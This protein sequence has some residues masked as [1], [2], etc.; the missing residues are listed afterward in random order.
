MCLFA[1]ALAPPPLAAQDAQWIWTPEHQHER[2]P[3]E[4]CFFR[5]TFS[6]AAAPEN[7]QIAIAADDRFELYVNS[8]QVGT[9]ESTQRLIPFNVTRYLVRGRNTVAVKVENVRGGTAALAARVMVKQSEGGWSSYSTDASWKTHLRPLPLWNLPIY[10]DSRWTE[11]QVFGLLGGTPP[12]DRIPDATA[13]TGAAGDTA[14]S[15]D[16][17][18]HD[19]FQIASE[20]EV[21]KVLAGEALGS[22]IALTFNEFGHVIASQEGGPLLLITDSNNDGALDKMRVYCE[23][24]KNCQGILSLNGDVY[25]TGEGPDGAALYRLSDGD[26]DGVLEHAQPLLKF[27]GPMGEHGPHALVLGPDGKIYLI[28]GNHAKPLAALDERSPH[29]KFYEGDLVGPRFEDPGGHA[30]GIKAPG[31]VV[32]RMDVDGTHVQVVA[33]GLRNCYDLAFNYEGELFVH[34]SDMESDVGAPWYRPTNLYHIIPGGEYGWRSGWAKWPEYFVDVLP[35]VLDT[36]RGSPTG[37]VFYNHIMFPTRYHDALFLAD[38]SEGRILVVR[39]KRSGATYT[40]SSEV[41]LKGEPLNVTDL[42]VGPDGSL[43]FTTGGR[44]TGGGLHRVRWRGTVP[45]NIRN[46]GADLTAVVRQPQLSAAWSRQNIAGLK[47]KLGDTWDRS[48]VGIAR[49]EQNPPNYRLRALDLLELYGPQPTTDLLI[50][51]AGDKNEQV[52]GKAAAMMGVHFDD[53]TRDKLVELLS[54]G[55]R[56]VRRKAAESLVR[57]GQTVPAEKVL[58][59]LSS[60]DRHEAWAARR[61]LERIDPAEWRATVLATGDQRLFIEGSLALLIAHPSRETALSVVERCGKLMEGFISDRNFVDMLR[62]MQVALHRGQL[63]AADVPA[64]RTKLENEFP[65]GDAIMNRE[66]ARLLVYLQVNTIHDRYLAYLKS[67]AAEAEKLHLAMHLRFLPDGMTQDQKR[68][69]LAFYETVQDDSQGNS[70]PHY[71]RNAARDFALSLGPEDADLLLAGGERWPSAA[72]GVLYKLPQ[73]LDAATF[74][75]LKQLDAKIAA[76]PSEAADRLKVGIVAVMARSGD[77]DSMDYL[78]GLWQREPERRQAVAMGLAQSP[79]GDNW[80]LLVDSLSVVEGGAA[81]EVL[82]KLVEVNRVP[83]NPEAYRHVILLGLV[84][85]AEGGDLAVN[86]LRFWS[87]EKPEGNETDWQKSLAAWQTWY[88][89]KYPDRPPAELPQVKDDAPWDYQELLKH[90]TGDEAGGAADRGAAVFAKAQCAKCHRYGDVGESMG[91]DLTSL[92]KRFMK[93]E[94][95][96]SIVFPSHVVSDQYASKAVATTRGRL[97]TGIVA[98]GPGGGVIVLQAN[99]EKVEVPRNEIEEI[100]PS[101]LSAMPEGLLDTLTLEEV[102]DLFKFL[103]TPPQEGVARKPGE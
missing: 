50:R 34:D 15:I 88:A 93:K 69:V 23:A 73:R 85:K 6:L 28:C 9:G 57:A 96:Q 7:A 36:G 76:D 25:V 26:R 20:F 71:V 1:A 103:T 12:W 60:D 32:L 37:A 68:D 84:L 63:A 41:F 22:L 31:G 14:R 2:V 98:P 62:L 90:L 101:K 38:W 64:L 91:P 24:V 45:E 4:A 51:L 43:Y 82:T 94:I 80:Q 72:L 92:S 10:N 30:A 56:A 5:K 52:R 70:V 81:R 53:A 95:L 13:T 19:Q 17:A 47:R 29:R 83:D 89:A 3:Q 65:S 97:L 44:G 78:R 21:T 54:D 55:D 18:G 48:I 58:A 100:S 86:L 61:L 8:R 59:L 42:A 79:G 99:G 67:D 74:A 33:G 16:P 49:S 27:E 87:G 66:L 39:L 35:A 46:L 102:A 40:A 77:Q 75:T 11:A